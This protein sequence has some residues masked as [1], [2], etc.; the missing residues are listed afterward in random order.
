MEDIQVAVGETPAWVN[1]EEA[2]LERAAVV[3]WLRQRD[4]HEGDPQTRFAASILWEISD[5]F[6]CASHHTRKVP[7]TF[8]GRPWEE[9]REEWAAKDRARAALV[10]EVGEKEVSRREKE[11]RYNAQRV[12]EGLAPLPTKAE[13]AVAR[14]AA[15]AARFERLRLEREADLAE[16]RAYHAARAAEVAT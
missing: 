11:A 4:R 16:S 12:S 1:S 3:A 13:R 2:K 9:W 8:M 10:A 15:S 6:A 14:A 7:T 5:I